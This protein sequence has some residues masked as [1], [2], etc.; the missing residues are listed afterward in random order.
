VPFS[1]NK[2]KKIGDFQ[3]DRLKKVIDRKLTKRQRRGMYLYKIINMYTFLAD[4]EHGEYFFS[5]EL[6]ITERVS[7]EVDIFEIKKI[8]DE[9][10]EYARKFAGLTKE[11]KYVNENG[12]K[13]VF[14]DNTVED[15]SCLLKFDFE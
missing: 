2:A 3:K 6:V 5:G 4:P 11:H 7:D 13:L 9:T 1:P 12:K 15:N 14:Q 8:Y 10:L